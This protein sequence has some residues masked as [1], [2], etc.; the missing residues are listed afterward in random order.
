[1]WSEKCQ[2][3][4]HADA[5]E[6]RWDAPLLYEAGWGK[7][8]LY[9]ISFWKWGVVDTTQ[10]YTAQWGAVL[11]RRTEVGEEDVARLTAECTARLRAGLGPQER[12]TL[13]SRD[14]RERE[15]MRQ[16]HR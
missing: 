5:C 11:Q 13:E 3:W 10:R 4:L 15:E 6:A 9:V 2:R 1:V 8:L 16:D 7:K 12:A 14:G